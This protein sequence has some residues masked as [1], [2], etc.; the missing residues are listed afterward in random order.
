MIPAVGSIVAIV[1]HHEIVAIWNHHLAI[2]DVLF[3][4]VALP[5][6]ADDVLGQHWIGQQKLVG[7]RLS[8]APPNGSIPGLKVLDIWID[9]ATR[10]IH[11]VDITVQEPDEPEHQMA[12]LGLSPRS[13]ENLL[14]V[15]TKCLCNTIIVLARH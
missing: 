9:P 15:L 12:A 11:H 5:Y 7:Y 10:E 8:K 13:W 14:S 2:D 6:H 4:H 3:Q 1:T